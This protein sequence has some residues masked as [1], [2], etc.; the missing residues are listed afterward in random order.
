MGSGIMLLNSWN[1]LISKALFSV[2]IIYYFGCYLVFV[3]IT[4]GT[5]TT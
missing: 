3:Y 5:L 4:G 2:A 1:G